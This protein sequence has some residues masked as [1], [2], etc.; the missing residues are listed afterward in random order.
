MWGG[1]KAV[2]LAAAL[3][4]SGFLTAEVVESCRSPLF[5]WICLMPL[6][7]AIRNLR[8]LVALFAGTIWG[9]SFY[10]FFPAVSAGLQFSDA[11]PVAVGCKSSFR[12][13]A[14]QPGVVHETVRRR[15][16]SL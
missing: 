16:A 9:A 13:M 1:L 11:D 6:F 2:A 15:F 8:P 4:F 10:L 3:I 5:S 14:P 7:I 12:E